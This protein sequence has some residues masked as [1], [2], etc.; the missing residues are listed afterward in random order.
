LRSHFK[1]IYHLF[2]KR[3]FKFFEKNSKE[4][5]NRKV[6]KTQYLDVSWL[7]IEV[8][9]DQKRIE[10]YLN[11]IEVNNN[12]ILH[13]GTGNS[14]FGSQFSKNNIVDSI[15]VM[16]DEFQ[17]AK[18]LAL[19]N[20]NCFKI[21]KYSPNLLKLPNKYDYIVDNN[22]SSF[23]CCKIHF[24]EMINNYK[25][26]LNN[27]G[28]IITDLKGM[29]YHQSSSFPISIEEIYVLFPELLVKVIDFTVILTKK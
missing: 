16:D 13:V 22:L 6:P 29:A 26:L 23:A 27:G 2:R 8:T 24:V 19:L 10:D 28:S 5:C 14:S 17:Y 3:V 7:T 4:N 11:N 18:S 15:T 20:Y 25:I 9:P 12:V 1:K 21:N